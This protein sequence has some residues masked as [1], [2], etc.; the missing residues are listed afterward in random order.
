MCLYKEET[1][2]ADF[3]NCQKSWN[4]LWLVAC[5]L[6]GC[7]KAYIKLISSPEVRISNNVFCQL[8]VIFDV[9]SSKIYVVQL[10]KVRKIRYYNSQVLQSP[11]YSTEIIDITTSCIAMYI[12]DFPEYLATYQYCTNTSEKE[13]W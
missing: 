7:L 4:S 8:K 9:L 3:Q 5:T 1:C 6:T 11:S 2:E 13:K 10:W 12:F